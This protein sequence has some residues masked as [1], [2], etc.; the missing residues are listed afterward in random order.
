[1]GSEAECETTPPKL[2]LFS[3]P[4]KAKEPSWMITSPIHTLVSVPFQWEE[5]PGKPRPCPSTSDTTISQSEPNAGRCLELPPR[6][7]AEAKVANVPSPKTVLDGPEEGRFVSYTLSFRKSGSFRSPDNKMVNKEK[8]MF[9]SSRWG[10]FRKAGRVL[11]GSFDFSTPVSDGG[12]DAEVKITR[13]RRKGSLLSLS[14]ARPHVLASIYESFKQV[15]P[16]RRGQEKMKK[17][18]S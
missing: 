13:A 3:F 4:G 8:V 14:Q 10:S 11:Q 7:L 6:L 17:K 12:D 16:W 2:S 9:G 1:M 15:V 5:A 18:D